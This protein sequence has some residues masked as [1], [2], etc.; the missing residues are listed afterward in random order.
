MHTKMCV[1]TCNG[2]CAIS[3]LYLKRGMCSS[4]PR[5]PLSLPPR[6]SLYSLFP[7]TFLLFP[8]PSVFPVHPRDSPIPFPRLRFFG[9]PQAVFACCCCCCCCSSY[10]YYNV[11]RRQ[12]QRRRRHLCRRRRFTCCRFR[13]RR[14]V[15]NMGGRRWHSLWRRHERWRRQG[16]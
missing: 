13:R 4:I 8:H 16:T 6:P 1:C 12:R 5:Y 15:R 7:P 14:P 10:Y 3:L 9:K 2:K 11:L